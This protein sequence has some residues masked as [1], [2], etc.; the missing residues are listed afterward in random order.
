MQFISH[1]LN[2]CN[3]IFHKW[4]SSYR[5]LY[6]LIFMQVFKSMQRHLSAY[7]MKICVCMNVW[8]QD[9]SPKLVLAE[10]TIF[11][12]CHFDK[13]SLIRKGMQRNSKT[14]NIDKQ[15]GFI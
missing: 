1:F 4:F 7:V 12:F 2:L 5:H 11:D 6:T 14:I 13:I 8:T 3:W 9:K 10:V 15:E